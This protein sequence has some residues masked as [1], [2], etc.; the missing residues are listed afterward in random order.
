MFECPIKSRVLSFDIGVKN[1]AFCDLSINKE[2]NNIFNIHDWQ[3]VDISTD[4]KDYNINDAVVKILTML[5]TKCKD[6]L[7]H[8]DE[9]VIEN[10]PVMKNPI[11]KSIQIVVFTYFHMIRY[12]KFENKEQQTFEISFCS[13]TNKNKVDRLIPKESKLII[14]Q[15]TEDEAKCQ[16]GYKFNKK[17]AHHLTTFFLDNCLNSVESSDN[18]W[19]MHY[20]KHK[21]KDDL[22][23][24]FL[25]GIHILTNMKV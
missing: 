10:Q 24:C 1:L 6:K 20:E 12:S 16:K 22:A 21:K 8:I 11:M 3:V 18:T 4:S 7:Q 14:R 15:K 23:D 13:A 9:V 17:H 19:K 25:Q 5:E 2:N